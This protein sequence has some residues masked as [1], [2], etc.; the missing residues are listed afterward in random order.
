[1]NKKLSTFR[2]QIDE[3]DAQL[4]ALMNQRAELAQS[5]GHLKKTDAI[6]H[7]D[8]EAQIYQH[9]QQINVGPLSNETVTLLFRE[10]ISACRSLQNPLTISYLGPAGT[11]SQSA[12]FAHFGH[13]VALLACNSIEE[14]FNSV[15]LKQAQFAV[16]PVEN[17]IEGSVNK[18]LDLLT[19]S[20]LHIVGEIKLLIQ[21]HLLRKTNDL[22]GIEKIYSHPQSLAQCY[23]WLNQRL[24]N[25]P[26]IP[27]ASN[28]Q[29]ASLA[30]SDA[31]AAAIAGEVAADVYGLNKVVENIQDELNNTTRFLV[32]GLLTAKPS[33]HDKTSLIVATK[34]RSG[35]VHDLLAPL[36]RHQVSMTKFESRPAHMGL[37]EYIFFIDIEG[38]EKDPAV[39]S[40]LEEMAAESIFIKVLGS[41]PKFE[42][43]NHDNC[44]ER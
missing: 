10:L 28:A 20:D 38:H 43:K 21:Q 32:L 33:G 8:R 30:E 35:A 24:P 34:N 18:T 19:T 44:N 29:A 17:S 5:V 6:Y 3:I 40:A 9:L 4:L 22:Q 25:V 13:K 2:Q 26:T 36:S 14:V 16:V 42:E 39:A 1:M 12:V 23:Q 27:V 37:W 41:Y 7:P 31:S 11:F 15:M